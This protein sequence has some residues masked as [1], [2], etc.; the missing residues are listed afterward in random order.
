MLKEIS[1]FALPSNHEIA[2]GATPLVIPLPRVIRFP[3]ITQTHT[4]TKAQR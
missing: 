2:Y 3:D 1:P 4:R